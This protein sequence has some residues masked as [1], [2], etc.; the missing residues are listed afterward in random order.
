MAVL[1]LKDATDLVEQ[2]Q[3]ID[4]AVDHPLYMV[5]FLESRYFPARPACN[6]SYDNLAK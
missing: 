5:R 3:V 6:V 4:K 1:A 2:N